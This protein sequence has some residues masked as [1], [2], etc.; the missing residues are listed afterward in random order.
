MSNIQL[1]SNMTLKNSQTELI[2]LQI[3]KIPEE[4]KTR[5]RTKRRITVDKRPTHEN[6]KEATIDV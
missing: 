6:P 3:T 2:Q 5:K 4:P 1:M